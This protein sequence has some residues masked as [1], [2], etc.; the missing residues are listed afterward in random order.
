MGLRLLFVLVLFM[1][2][3]GAAKNTVFGY[4][5]PMVGKQNWGDLET[6]FHKIGF[7]QIGV[8]A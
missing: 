2:S 3:G 5:I 1:F 4:H 8:L 7:N 6:A